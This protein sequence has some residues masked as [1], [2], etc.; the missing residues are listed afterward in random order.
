MISREIPDKLTKRDFPLPHH[1]PK[2]PGNLT[3][4]FAMGHD[5]IH[6]RFPRHGP[7]YYRARNQSVKEALKTLNPAKKGA[8]ADQYFRLLDDLG[9]GLEFLGQHQEAV[10]LM[11]QKLVDQRALGYTD[12][13]L[14]STYAN[15]GT[16]LIL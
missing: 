16:F 6:E 14:Y 13:E 3:L 11:R 8:A 9:V 12:K 10:D 1:I 2:Y 5:V 15:L 7:A 4:R